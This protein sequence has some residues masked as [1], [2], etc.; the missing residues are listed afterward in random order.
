MVVEAVTSYPVSAPLFPVSGKFSENP[1]PLRGPEPREVPE[2]QA[3]QSLGSQDFPTHNRE[4]I[5]ERKRSIDEDGCT[6][7]WDAMLVSTSQGP[8]G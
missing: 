8:I 2:Q 5:R 3:Y 6:S 4:D 1:R 7:G